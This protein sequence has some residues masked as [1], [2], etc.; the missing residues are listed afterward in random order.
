MAG[1]VPPGDLHQRDEVGGIEGV[2]ADIPPGVGGLRRDVGNAQ[3]RRG[4]GHDAVRRG[5]AVEQCGEL[6]LQLQLF[7]AGFLDKLRLRH[8]SL[9][10]CSILDAGHDVRDVVK[11]KAVLPGQMIEIVLHHLLCVGQ[12]AAVQVVYGDLAALEGEIRRPAGADDAGRVT[13]DFHSI[14]S[15]YPDAGDRPEGRAGPGIIHYT[16]PEGNVKSDFLFSVIIVVN[17]T[18]FDTLKIQLPVHLL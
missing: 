12:Q 13:C 5:A 6:P 4:R 7:R 17:I 15:F 11:G 8:R 14:N 16:V 9:R 2:R 18:D 1:L 10:I 3:A